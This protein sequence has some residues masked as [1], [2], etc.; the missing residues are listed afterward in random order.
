M[1]VLFAP[2]LEKQNTKQ[3]IFSGVHGILFLIIQ[4]VLQKYHSIW[5]LTLVSG[6]FILSLKMSLP[7]I[8]KKTTEELESDQSTL[9]I[10]PEANLH[11]VKKTFVQN[12]LELAFMAKYLSRTSDYL[13]GIYD[14]QFMILK[15]V[16][17]YAKN[18]RVLVSDVEVKI[19]AAS[20]SSDQARVGADVGREHMNN[21]S[22]S[23]KSLED[24]GALLS[25]FSSVIHNLTKQMGE[26]DDIVFMAKLLSFNA[27]IEAAR[28]GDL[29]QGMSVV[30]LEMTKLAQQIGDTSKEIQTTLKASNEN[31]LSVNTK[32]TNLLSDSTELINSSQSSLNAIIDE[33]YV[34]TGK[35]SEVTGT[36]TSYKKSTADLDGILS[37]ITKTSNT[38]GT[39]SANTNLVRLN[40]EELNSFNQQNNE[41]IKIK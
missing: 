9:N 39:A 15:K 21:L 37:Q 30:A 27:T 11:E 17:D 7:Y 18:T 20:T 41:L 6:L 35:I 19:N 4:L 25:E 3:W 24:V 14:D 38:L 10:Q 28:V 29:G 36:L 40:L 1:K 32:V 23:V 33:I 26:I 16:D 12:S 5:G 31:L 34:L 13:L 22:T 2:Y 8:V